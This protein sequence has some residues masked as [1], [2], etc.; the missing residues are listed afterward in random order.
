MR[1]MVQRFGMFHY[2]NDSY[3]IV[4]DYPCDTVGRQLN[5]GRQK[6]QKLDQ[7]HG[8]VPID[9]CIPDHDVES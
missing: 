5:N 7:G 8:H 9:F 4:N 2:V 1:M 3:R 6:P